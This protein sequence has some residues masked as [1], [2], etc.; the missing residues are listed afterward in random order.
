MTRR[1][2]LS[3]SSRM[4][5]SD[6]TDLGGYRLDAGRSYRGLWGDEKPAK[7]QDPDDVGKS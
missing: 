6:E 4:G 7:G 3:G 2:P 5:G 1:Y